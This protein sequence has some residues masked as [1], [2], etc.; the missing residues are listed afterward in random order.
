MATR[1]DDGVIFEFVSIGA[2]VKVSAIDPVTGV[3]AS[4]VGDP[5]SGEMTL[6]RTALRKLQF[7]LD[8]KKGGRP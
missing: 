6:R 4:I 3:E 5:L 2:Y 8:K 7:V 1:G